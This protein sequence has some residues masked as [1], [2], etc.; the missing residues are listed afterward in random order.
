M[1][2]YRKSQN[3]M[4]VEEVAKSKGYN[5]LAYHGTKSEFNE[6]SGSVS[7]EFGPGIYLSFTEGMASFFAWNSKGAGAEKVNQLYVNANNPYTITKT[8]WIKKTLNRTPRTVSEKIRS[9]GYDSIIGI[10]I[11]GVD[12]QLVVFNPSQVKL[13]SEKTYDDSGKEIPLTE[14]FNSGNPDMRY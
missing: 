13:A 14:R 5:T 1:N 11:N 2:W 3:E 6:F 12:I 8:D 10:G 7:G 9:Q 4:S